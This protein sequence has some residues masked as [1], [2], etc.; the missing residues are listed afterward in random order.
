MLF[1]EVNSNWTTLLNEGAERIEVYNYK[2]KDAFENF[3]EE[4]ENNLE[5]INCFED[6]NED[7]DECA[8]RW[9]SR[10]NRIILKC[11]PKIRINK[12]KHNKVLT[13]LFEKK[14]ALKTKLFRMK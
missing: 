14:E 11:F 3:K 4:T 2:N 1:L 7:L 9:L 5:L 10:L 12:R 8:D 13:E 6:P